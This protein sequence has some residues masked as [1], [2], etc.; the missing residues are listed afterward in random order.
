MSRPQYVQNVKKA[1]QKV[2]RAARELTTVF[3]VTCCLVTVVCQMAKMPPPPNGNCLGIS[4]TQI[5]VF[6]K[7]KL[8]ILYQTNCKLQLNSIVDG[9]EVS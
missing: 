4:L 5:S 2:G 1:A 3:S 6:F 8:E 7:N 9:K